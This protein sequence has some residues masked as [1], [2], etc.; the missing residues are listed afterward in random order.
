M[1]EVAD[2][3]SS[4]V[5]VRLAL[6]E[7]EEVAELQTIVPVLSLTCSWPLLVSY[8]TDARKGRS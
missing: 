6:D 3:L 5:V 8:G 7:E 1:H 4:C 2:E